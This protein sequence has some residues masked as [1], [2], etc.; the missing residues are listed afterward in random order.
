MKQLLRQ[1]LIEQRSSLSEEEIDYLSRRIVMRV[2]R[3]QPYLEAKKIALYH[4]V[5]GEADPS[6]LLK[7]TSKQFYLPVL[8]KEETKGIQFVAINKE[9][10]FLKNRFS[11]PEPVYTE[12]D[13]V[14]GDSL[15]LVLVPLVGFDKR[16]NRLGMGGG[17]Y[18]R[19]FAF[20]RVSTMRPSG[21]P[22]LMGFAYQ[23]QE[24]EKLDAENWDVPLDYIVTNE[25]VFK[26]EN[27]R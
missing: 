25:S 27:N 22:V 14:D 19:C 21:K 4:A 9:T 15:D 3:T 13:I 11:I 6:E 24:V 2:T 12:S 16:G 20:K 8:A 18:D 23:F 5:N 10:R 26:I 17:F 7:D 1:S